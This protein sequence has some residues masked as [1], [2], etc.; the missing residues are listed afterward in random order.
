M[1]L[2]VI[3]DAASVDSLIEQL[4]NRKVGVA[5]I[6][7]AQMD[8]MIMTLGDRLEVSDVLVR[9][10]ASPGVLSGALAARAWLVGDLDELPIR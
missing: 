9:W 6:H 10:A 3:R 2:S 5:T 7:H 8:A 1:S 4:G